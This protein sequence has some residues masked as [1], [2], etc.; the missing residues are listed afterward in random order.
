MSRL[1]NPHLILGGARSGKST[2][3][4]ALVM[5]MAPPHRYVATAQILD[6]EMARRVREHRE[7]RGTMWRTIECPVHLADTLLALDQEPAPILV[8][9]L[10]LWYSNLLLSLED[11]AVKA[12]ISS[13]CDVL[14]SARSPMFLVSNEVGCG[15]V[16]DNAL[17]RSYRDLAGWANQRVAAACRA[18]TYVIAGIPVLLKPR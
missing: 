14:H 9:C 5:S 18:V 13:V 6:E 15:I 16:P 10:T 8:D 4:E 12:H 3:A 1:E 2:Y 7:R 17:A 11:R